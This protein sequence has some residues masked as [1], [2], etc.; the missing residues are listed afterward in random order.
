MMTLEKLASYVYG[1]IRAMF[2]EAI[3]DFRDLSQE[4]ILSVRCHIHV[5]SGLEIIGDTT[6]NQ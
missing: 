6:Y 4:Q 5:T 3:E 1:F 2:N